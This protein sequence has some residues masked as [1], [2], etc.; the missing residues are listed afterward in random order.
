VTEFVFGYGSLVDALERGGSAATLRGYRRC[1]QVAMDNSVDLPGYKYYVDAV[2]GERPDVYVTFVD[3]APDPDSSVSGVVF[4]VNGDALDALDARERNY[5]RREVTG[6]VA[7]PTGGCVWAYFGTSDA[8]ERYER[9]RSAG[10]AVVSRAYLDVV[11]HDPPVPVRDLK[12][13]DLLA[14]TANR[15]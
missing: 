8:R 1:W 10:T 13:V 15:P 2:T 11:R 4:P 12:R 6:R 3:L 14:E 9:G 7:P 5:E